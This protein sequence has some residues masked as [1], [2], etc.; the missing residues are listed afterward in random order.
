MQIFFTFSKGK[1]VAF[2]PGA[3]NFHL[4]SLQCLGLQEGRQTLERGRLS[5]TSLPSTSCSRGQGSHSLLTVFTSV[6]ST[7][8]AGP[9][10]ADLYTI[11]QTWFVATLRKQYEKLK[12]IEAHKEEWSAIV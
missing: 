2:K 10:K 5:N 1:T 3:V 7:P 8:G 12:G 11:G 6:K 9:W 4:I